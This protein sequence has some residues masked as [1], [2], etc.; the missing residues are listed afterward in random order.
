MT[1]RVEQEAERKERSLERI[2]AGAL[3]A[4]IHDHGPITLQTL[5]SAAKRIVGQLGGA[6]GPAA[7]ARRRWA[8]TTAE[9]RSEVTAKGGRTAWASMTPEERSEEM[10]RRAA[11][12]RPPRT[13][14]RRDA[15]SES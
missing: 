7:M 1:T 8:D 13:R 10:R 12:R 3:R 9:E 6:V 4:A 11:K 15:S 5:G 2:V 14:R